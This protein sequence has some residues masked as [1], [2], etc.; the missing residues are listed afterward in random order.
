[1]ER[2]KG[3][4]EGRKKGKG[5]GQGGGGREETKER[6][7]ERKNRKET[8]QYQVLVRHG[9]MCASYTDTECELGQW[10]W[11]IVCPSTNV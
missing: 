9:V 5:K 1:M 8:C 6:R 2:S 4:M 7:R 11:K 3:G 10:V